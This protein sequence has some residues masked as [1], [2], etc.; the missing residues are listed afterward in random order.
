MRTIKGT[1]LGALGIV[2]AI[3]AVG[4]GDTINGVEN[5]WVA[6]GYVLLAI[7]L[8]CAALVL[9]AFAVNAE[10]E[11]MEQEQRSKIKRV[12]THTNEWRN[13]Q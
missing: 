12:A 4:V 3:T 6:F 13:V 2:L 10:N 11:R 1:V 9:C 8:L 5:G 7:A